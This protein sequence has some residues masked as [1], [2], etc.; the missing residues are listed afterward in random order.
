MN[1]V[2]IIVGTILYFFNN[3]DW[4]KVARTQHEYS[5]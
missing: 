2:F 1:F 5:V 4:N 3:S